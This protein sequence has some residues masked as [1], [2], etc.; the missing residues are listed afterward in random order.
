MGAG[1]IRHRHAH[2]LVTRFTTDVALSPCT[3]PFHPS[4][5]SVSRTWMA[6]ESCLARLV[7][8]LAF[9]FV[10]CGGELLRLCD[11]VQHR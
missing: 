2:S 5:S 9:A 4:I 11:L 6:L 10:G 3:E 7:A 1:Q 8:E